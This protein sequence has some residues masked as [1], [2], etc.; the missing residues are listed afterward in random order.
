MLCEA[1]RHLESMQRSR[2]DEATHD[3]TFTGGYITRPKV[4]APTDSGPPPALCSREH[5]SAQNLI[6]RARRVFF[7]FFALVACRDDPGYADAIRIEAAL[8]IP[9]LRHDEKKPGGV[10]EVLAFFKGK[11]SEGETVSGALAI[12]SFTADAPVGRESSRVTPASLVC[13]TVGADFLPLRRPDL[14]ALPHIPV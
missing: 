3:V 8:G 2:Q 12:N 1:R 14:F 5:E 11:H 7:R 13:C 10:A 9:V 4:D 6:F